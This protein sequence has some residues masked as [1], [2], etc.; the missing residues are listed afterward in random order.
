MARLAAIV[1]AS[2]MAAAAMAAFAATAAPCACKTDEGARRLSAA[3]L[4]F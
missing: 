4:F 3:L 1:L 2:M